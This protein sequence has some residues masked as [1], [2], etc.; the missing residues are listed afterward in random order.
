MTLVI[1]AIGLSLAMAAAWWWQRRVSNIGWVDVFWTFATATG[2][3]VLSLAWSG[4]EGWWPRRLLV[5]AIVGVWAAR[6]GLYV[7]FR[8]AG[9]PEDGR[10]VELRRQWGDGLQRKMFGFLQLQAGVSLVLAAAIGL[11]ASRPAPGLRIADLAGALI[12]IV[13]IAGEALADQQIKA[14]RRDPANAGKVC[15]IGLWAWSRHPNYFF[16]WLGWVAWAVIAANPANPWSFAALMAPAFMFYLL[17]FASGIPPLE[18]HMLATRGDRFRAYQ[19]RTSAFFPLPPR[20][21]S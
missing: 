9:A 16:E 6:L 20:S 12:A 5:L 18:K 15:D 10:Y 14:F 3:V 7:A 21:P 19:A 11:A 4:E 8:V 13:A 1:V 2:G 17:V